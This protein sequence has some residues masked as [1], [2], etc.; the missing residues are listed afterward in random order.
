LAAFFSA[1]ELKGDNMYSCEKCNKL[2][3]GVK[4]SKVLELPEVLC[5][6]LKRFRHELMF[7]AKISNYVA[8]P[9]EGLDMRPYLHKDCVSQ[10]TSY[11]LVSVICHHGTAG[12]GHYTCYSLNCISEQWFEF[13]DQYVTQVSPETVQN[14]EAYVLFYKKSSAGAAKLRQRAVELMELSHHEPSLMQFYVSKQWVNKFN[15]F[16]EPG[17]IDNSDFLCIHGG[18]RPAREP[19]ANQLCTI[20][21]QAVWE[22]LYD[23]FGGGPA[24][25]RLY[26]CPTC[27]QEQEAL[28]HRVK[29]ELEEFMQLNKE[30]QQAEESPVVIYAIAMNWFRQ[31]Q[32][33]VRGKE[34]EPP[35]QIDNSSICTINKNGQAVLK[36]GSD[37]AQL[38]EELWSFFHRVYG[39][40]P[41]VILRSP[42]QRTGSNVGCNS[43]GSTSQPPVLLRTVPVAPES[44]LVMT[45]AH[46][47]CSTENITTSH[48]GASGSPGGVGTLV[49]PAGRAQS[50]S[51]DNI[52]VRMA[53]LSASGHIPSEK[54]DSQDMESGEPTP[55]CA[56][57][58]CC[59]DEG[60]Q[61]I[62]RVA[63]STS[64]PTSLAVDQC[65][66]TEI[67]D[68]ITSGEPLV[69]IN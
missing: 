17:P 28:A 45:Q 49:R 63:S 12:G 39:G 64:V 32:S 53:A 51:S 15:T 33:F 47:A 38:S 43:S 11:D 41:E 52:T 25:N 68:A 9:L 3:N 5:I 46:K 44:P 36:M 58:G 22:Y 61:A 67:V 24:C 69:A 29:H 27:H 26:A 56:L 14:C 40:G 48:S 54:T 35:G 21:S 57:P 6:H 1:D 10:V 23:T 37:Y 65:E 66:I 31:W 2:R 18:V 13:D 7:S 34:P 19:Y 20:L 16:A 50:I 30:F 59:K 42:C 4:Y 8:F 60:P 62:T 55:V